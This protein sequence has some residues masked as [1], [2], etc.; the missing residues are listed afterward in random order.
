MKKILVS[1]RSL[2]RSTT[3]NGEIVG[4]LA[5]VGVAVTL[6]YAAMQTLGSSASS[7]A[8]QQGTAIK[9]LPGQ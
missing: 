9:A 5:A 1:I 7:K 2:L 8:T 6:G 3:G 4:V